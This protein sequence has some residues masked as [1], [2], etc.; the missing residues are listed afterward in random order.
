MVSDWL[1]KLSP[2]RIILLS[3]ATIVTIGTIL[4]VLPIAQ[5]TSVS[6]IDT[7]FIAISAITAT[8]LEAVDLYKFSFFGHCTIAALMQIGSL[9]IIILTL[10]ILHFFF[11]P[12][13]T[14]KKVAAELLGV[15]RKKDTKKMLF[16]VIGLTLIVEL[17]G[18]L[19]IFSKLIL[20]FSLSKAAFHSI[21]LAISAFSNTGFSLL[22]N[23]MEMYNS[24]FIVLST[25]SLLMLLGAIG[26]ETLKEGMRYIISITKKAKH[27]FSLSSKIIWETTFIL[28]FISVLILLILES[29]H[30]FASMSWPTSIINTLFYV[31]SSMGTGFQTVATGAMKVPSLVLIMIIAFIGGSPGSTGSGI[32]TTTVAIFFAA[33]RSTIRKK[34]H[35]ILQGRRIDIEQVSKAIAMITLSIPFVIAI[36]FLLLITEPGIRLLDSIF[37]AVS[38]FANLGM[39]TGITGN[40]SVIGKL[41]ICITMLVGKVG[42]FTLIFAIKPPEESRE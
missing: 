29:N 37:E 17:I 30:A 33:L 36:S 8:G 28:I 23:S 6:F 22:P 14:T 21:F 1:A 16:F 2:S 24:S 41:L 18:A 25:L 11:N 35:V 39:S 34:D 12:D 7:L 4:L 5:A 20:D 27:I 32:K 19:F 15:E 13:R 3:T 10:F 40:L 26:F 31:I 38:G 9:G 42:P